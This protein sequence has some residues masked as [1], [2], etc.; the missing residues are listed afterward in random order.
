MSY[1]IGAAG[2]PRAILRLAL[3]DEI[4]PTPGRELE[5]SVI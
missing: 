1:T 4:N 3:G 5:D 2:L